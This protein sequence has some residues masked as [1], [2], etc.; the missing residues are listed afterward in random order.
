MLT[1]AMLV[2]VDS[3]CGLSL[4]CIFLT[5][6]SED[7]AAFPLG[8]RQKERCLLWPCELKFPLSAQMPQASA[9][10]TVADVLCYVFFLLL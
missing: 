5:L 4:G 1:A 2:A 9:S 7:L 10:W 3:P 6:R 8:E